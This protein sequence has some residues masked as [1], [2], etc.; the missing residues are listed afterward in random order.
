MAEEGVEEGGGRFHGLPLIEDGK[1]LESQ[2]RG[3]R[4]PRLYASSSRLVPCI[5]PMSDRASLRVESG[6]TSAVSRGDRAPHRS[7]LRY[8]HLRMTKLSFELLKLLLRM[9]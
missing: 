6:M 7:L 9:L 5:W 1:L 3:R 4:A 8:P 2:P